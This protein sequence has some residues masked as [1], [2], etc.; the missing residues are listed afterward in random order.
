M[1]PAPASSAQAD[2]D[3]ALKLCDR[4]LRAASERGLRVSVA[5]V[6]PGGDPIHQDRMDD[7][8]AAGVDVALAT[9]ATAARFGCAS[10]VVADRYG[11]AVT[12][13]AALHPAPL[14]TAPGGVPL[15][16][17]GRLI[18]ALGVGGHEPARCAE[19]AL[20]VSS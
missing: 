5:V 2:L 13:L 14:L 15:V 3:R 6:D 10:E 9:A 17:G 12:Q 16:R 20:A 7:A 1:R 4:V 11:E 18:G 19:L 8:P